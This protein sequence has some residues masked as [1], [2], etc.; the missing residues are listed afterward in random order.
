MV[1]TRL[2]HGDKV[3][4]LARNLLIKLHLSNVFCACMWR[5]E[6]VQELEAVLMGFMSCEWWPLHLF[7]KVNEP[8][9]TRLNLRLMESADGAEVKRIHAMVVTFD[10][11]LALQL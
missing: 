11:V 3:V 1:E 5:G 10:R 2:A 9:R 6:M 8:S 4:V 7:V